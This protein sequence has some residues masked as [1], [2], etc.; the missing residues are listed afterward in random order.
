MSDSLTLEEQEPGIEARPLTGTEY[1]KVQAVLQRIE[2]LRR[3]MIA[4]TA[5]GVVV[6]SFIF[7]YSGLHFDKSGYFVVSYTAKTLASALLFS[8]FVFLP[9]ILILGYFSNH[10]NAHID[11]LAKGQYEK[12]IVLDYLM[13]DHVT[14][15]TKRPSTKD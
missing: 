3:A 7:I 14:R 13:S 12:T 2:G 15:P 5:V 1:A 8:I 9:A 4:T 10:V 11:D 6:S